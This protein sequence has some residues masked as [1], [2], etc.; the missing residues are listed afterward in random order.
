MKEHLLEVK[1]LP[2]PTPVGLLKRTRLLEHIKSGA[3]PSGEINRRLVLISAPA[4]FGKTTLALQWL[5]ERKKRTAWY[6]LEEGDNDPH[7]FWTYF[8][9]AL[10]K[11][12]PGLGEFALENIRAGAI[13]PE[14]HPDHSLLVSLLNEMDKLDQPLYIVL[15]DYQVIED[16]SIQ[17]SL[18][19]LVD[20]LPGQI[21]LIITSRFDPPWPLARWRARGQ[22]VE[23]RAERL[24][25]NREEIKDFLAYHGLEEINQEDLRRLA[26]GTEG[27][28][29][30]L[31]LAAFSLQQQEDISAFIQNFSGS[32]RRI[33]NFLTDEVLSLQ[34]LEVKKFLYQ[35]SILKTLDPSLCQAV[36]RRGNSGEILF[37]LESQNLFLSPVDPE[38]FRYRY[39]PLFAE[40]LQKRLERE[41]SHNIPILH[42]R[43][44]HHLEKNRELVEAV[45]HFL[46]ADL[47]REA[48]TI[49]NQDPDTLWK[50]AGSH[51][52]ARWLARVPRELLQQFPRLFAY[53]AMFLIIQGNLRAIKPFLDEIKFVQP[54][55][56]KEKREFEG[57]VALIRTYFAIFQNDQRDLVDVSREIGDKL[58]PEKTL[59]H[60]FAALASGDASSIEGNLEKASEEF[61]LALQLGKQSGQHFATLLAAWK[62]GNIRWYR[63]QLK[64]A[65]QLC[66][67]MIQF[68]RDKGLSSIPRTGSIL[69][70]QAVIQREQNQMEKARENISRAVRICGP[71]KQILGW[72]LYFHVLIAFSGGNLKQ[73]GKIL[74]DMEAIQ[75]ENRLPTILAD[76]IS[77]WRARL[78]LESGDLILAREYLAAKNIT[79]AETPSF[80]QENGFMV[81][82]RLELAENN[83][84]KAAGV[85][86]RMEEHFTASQSRGLRIEIL[87]LK[88]LISARKKD[89]ENALSFITE[90]LSLGEGQ[91]FFR[92]FLD[93]GEELI[94]LLALVPTHSKF[95]AFASRLMQSFEGR[96][97]RLGEKTI[98]SSPS[99]RLSEQELEILQLLARGLSSQDIADSL[100][101]SPGNVRQQVNNIYSQLMVDSREEAVERARKLDLIREEEK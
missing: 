4:G 42:E 5:E 89:S 2:P 45:E 20:N 11:V 36:T 101:L 50:K 13:S 68:A 99:T 29:S 58:P 70:L 93:Q 48:L 19:F 86:D 76:Y 14:P 60:G 96:T 74:A 73:A 37:Q 65:I 71:E 61:E 26:R 69:A 41:E 54:Q 43:A 18:Y 87:L 47:P 59:W 23:I 92:P 7:I 88:A 53:R 21:Q 33:L 62:L 67:E 94:R 97:P 52:L 63:G 51:R 16:K 32:H 39:H 17:D 79:G 12:E 66:E 56:E 100:F 35:T 82:A 84:E 95:S 98:S 31:Q 27:W 25:L 85:L 15:D 44:A 80:G 34:D 78:Y 8:I 91:N 75:H 46:A 38:G 72:S 55:E 9:S 81:L 83:L 24:R 1:I 28:I 64:E 22:L 57:M 30:S 10:Q 49:I 77:F 90:A 3:S 6:A 40:L